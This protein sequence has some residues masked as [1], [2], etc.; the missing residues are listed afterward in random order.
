MDVI[1]L[2]RQAE[3][4]SHKEILIYNPLSYDL[5]WKYDGKPQ[6]TVVSKENKSFRDYA[7]DA[8]K[9]PVLKIFIDKEINSPELDPKKIQTKENLI[10]FLQ[11]APAVSGD[12]LQNSI[13][14]ILKENPKAVEDYKK[15]K[16]QALMFLIGQVKRQLKGGDSTQIIDA[17]KQKLTSA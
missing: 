2:V 1:D 6:E 9:D 3:A 8:E 13:E 10:K 15:G 12:E 17:L 14:Q 16:E 11:K 5:E 7:P 4:D